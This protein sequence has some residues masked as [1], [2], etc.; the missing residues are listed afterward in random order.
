MTS[1]WIVARGACILIDR[2]RNATLTIVESRS[3]R[4]PPRVVTTITPRRRGEK[5]MLSG[6][7]GEV[8]SVS[9]VIR[10]IS[11]CTENALIYGAP[12]RKYT[13]HRSG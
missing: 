5:L 6:A 2:L 1:H 11:L 3:A 13:E 4:N 8:W 12:L 9:A 7:G 10:R